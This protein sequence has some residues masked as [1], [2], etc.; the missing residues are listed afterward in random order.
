V[1]A[2]GCWPAA[3]PANTPLVVDLDA[4]AKAMGRDAEIAQKIEQA[5]ESLN[6]QLIQAAQEMEKQ[7]QKQKAEMGATPSASERE[8]YRQAELRVQQHIRNNKAIA[9]QARQAVRDRQILVFRM[10][11]KPIAAKIA[12]KR[13]AKLVTVATHEVVWFDPSA[14]ITAEVIAEM[15]AYAA[16][17][18]VAPAKAPPPAQTNAPDSTNETTDAK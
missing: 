13:N 15:R 18:S 2:A 16:T 3:T 4:V 6:A 1:A 14:D 5:T 7:L 8:K 9:E 17:A 11:V 12:Q 10:E